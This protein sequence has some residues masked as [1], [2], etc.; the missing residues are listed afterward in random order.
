MNPY[1]LWIKFLG[2]ILT[3]NSAMAYSRRC[4]SVSLVVNSD[5]AIN[6]VLTLATNP[7]V[8]IDTLPYMD[9]MNNYCLCLCSCLMK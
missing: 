2:R 9:A 4:S 3:R 8:L 1:N 7:E 5:A 6:I